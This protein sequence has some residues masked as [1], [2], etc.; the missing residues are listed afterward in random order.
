MRED[1]A[2][3]SLRSASGA[4]VATWQWRLVQALGRTFA[5]YEAFGPATEQATRDFQSAQEVAVDGIVGPNTRA[6]MVRRPG[7]VMQPRRGTQAMAPVT[8][9]HPRPRV[10]EGR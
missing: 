1:Q 4:A 7:P 3:G 8:P 6:A 2:H 5:V 10:T 9:R